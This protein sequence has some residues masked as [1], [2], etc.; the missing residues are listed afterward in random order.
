MPNNTTTVLFSIRSI[1]V[2]IWSSMLSGDADSHH[3]CR[4]YAQTERVGAVASQA[5]RDEA[6]QNKT[7]IHIPHTYRTHTEQIPYK[8]HAHTAKYR[9]HAVQIPYTLYKYRTLCTGGEY[10]DRTN[11]VH[12]PVQI[13]C[14]YRTNTVQIPHPNCTI[15]WCRNDD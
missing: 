1:I 8:Y 9:T 14:T 12:I 13:P 15:I 4:S 2:V 3:V 6:A 7:Q 10:K 11:T 5:G